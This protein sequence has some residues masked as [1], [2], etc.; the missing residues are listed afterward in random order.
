MMRRSWLWAIILAGFIWSSVASG[1]AADF[2]GNRWGGSLAEVTRRERAN[3]EFRDKQT[4]F[5]RTQVAGLACFLVYRFE[6][7]R[8]FQ[9]GY[10]IEPRNRDLNHCL[11][12]YQKLLGRLAAEYGKP[13]E[14]Q[15]LWSDNTYRDQPES[16]GIAV[17]L[18]HLARQ[19]VWRTPSTIIRLRL[20]GEDRQINLVAG[21]FSRAHEEPTDSSRAV[22]FGT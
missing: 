5:Y 19:A 14:N 22:F 21:F 8:L 17:S 4:L 3:L 10:V 12:D 9:A 6:Q 20:W 1:G 2:R 15:I 13:Q 16:Y 18:G 11:Q 7:N